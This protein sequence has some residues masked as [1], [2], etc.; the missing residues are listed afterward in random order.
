MCTFVINSLSRKFYGFHKFTA[1]VPPESI[2]TDRSNDLQTFTIVLSI[3]QT[4]LFGGFSVEVNEQDEDGDDIDST[5]NVLEDSSV[6]LPITL[7][8]EETAVGVKLAKFAQVYSI[9]ARSLT[10]N[11]QPSVRYAGQDVITGKLTLSSRRVT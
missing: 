1:P 10:K 2:S 4:G 8:S 11:G 9:R 3:P 5:E 7:S 6:K